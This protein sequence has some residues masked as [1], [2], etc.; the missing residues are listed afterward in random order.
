MKHISIDP[1]R[2]IPPVR[3]LASS[4]L[5]ASLPEATSTKT[6]PSH[7]G[8]ENASIYFIGTATTILEWEGMRVM[9]DPNFLHA[10]DHV[11]LGPGVTATR[12][13]NPAV[14]LH[15][16]PR[17]DLVLLS[18]YHEDHFDRKVEESLRRD[19]PIITTSHAK[20][21]LTAK[22]SDSFQQVYDLEPFEQML[23][24]VKCD[25]AQTR[26]PRM[27]VTGTP[28]KH[29]PTNKVVEKLNQFAAAR[30][31]I[32]PTNG[33]MVELGYG[34]TGTLQTDFD[35]GYRIY[36]S[37]DTLMVD[38]LKE[39]PRRFAG[40][41]LDLMLI[42]LGGTT[43]PHPNMW[44]LTMMVTMDAKQGVELVRLIRPDLTI[45]IHYDDYNV[46]ASRWRISSRRC[47]RRA[48]GGMWCISTAR[49]PTI[50]E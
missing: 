39:I 48:W 3:D 26:Q 4:S 19:L 28:G 17:I 14:D 20:A 38:D 18:H 36:I 27:R 32:P 6:H 16:L 45:P 44:P 24:S 30:M 23:V 33:W 10:G 29:I 8:G 2:N 15:E 42:H 9:T 50:S 11:H 47:R 12:Q 40:Q 1:R 21:A 49:K 41:K 22:G 34:S 7:A 31:K 5:P 35:V 25:S 43:V 46:F 13:T 37:G